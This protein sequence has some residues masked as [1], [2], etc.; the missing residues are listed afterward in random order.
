MGRWKKMDKNIE[1]KQFTTHNDQLS[2]LKSRN[3][4]I[5]DDESALERLKRLN[6]YRLTG[7]ALPNKSGDNYV[8]G[9]SF[10]NT[11]RVYEFDRKLRNM[12]LQI[13][14]PIE[15]AIRAQ[16]SYYHSSKYGPLGY[17]NSDYFIDIENHKKFM[18]DLEGKK[19]RSKELFVT[20]HM[21]HYNEKLPLW[22]AVELFSFGTLSMFFKNMN[23]DDKKEFAKQNYNIKYAYLENWL[24]TLTF[25]RNVCAHYARAYNKKL[26]TSLKLYRENKLVK[27]RLLSSLHIIRRLTIDQNQWISFFSNFEA[28][29]E[30]YS[31]VIDDKK[32]GLIENWKKYI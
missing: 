22:V 32:L 21:N 18:R 12:L 2:L 27:N 7:Y 4:E 1:I 17:E 13:I 3:M 11:Y 26:P 30:E 15:I 25:I 29:L 31:D 19:A 28:L 16:L 6:Y 9:T 20:H 24:H 23:L 10:E 8:E 14:E 5:D